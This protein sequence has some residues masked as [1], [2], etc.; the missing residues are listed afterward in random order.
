MVTHLPMSIESVHSGGLIATGTPVWLAS[1]DSHVHFVGIGVTADF[2]AVCAGFSEEFCS[3]SSFDISGRNLT[4][5]GLPYHRRQF[6]RYEGTSRSI[7]QANYRFGGMEEMLALLEER[8]PGITTT[9][10]REGQSL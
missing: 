9:M 6:G 10:F 7:D 1:V 8:T 5:G 2:A 3:I 4:L